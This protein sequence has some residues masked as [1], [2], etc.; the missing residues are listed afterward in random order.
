MVA[1]K[2]HALRRDPEYLKEKTRRWRAAN[3]D[4]YKAN[5]VRN[6]TSRS[7][8]YKDNP[9]YYLWRSA[10]VRAKK[11]NIP[12]DIEVE[13]V[14]VPDVCP[15]TGETLDILTNNM[16]TACSLDKVDNF[17]GYVKGNVRV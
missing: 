3:P 14:V 16:T 6:E 5:S 4:K 7:K 8:R 9:A 15:I 10:K 1:K 17:K 11:F 12:F 13:D 2:E